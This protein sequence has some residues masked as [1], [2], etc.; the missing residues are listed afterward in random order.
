[1]KRFIWPLLM[2]LALAACSRKGPTPTSSPVPTLA[3]NPTLVSSVTPTPAGS[4]VPRITVVPSATR[5]QPTSQEATST[6]NA[7]PTATTEFAP[8]PLP[9]S[10]PTR[11]VIDAGPTAT[12]SPTATRP[13]SPLPTPTVGESPLDLPPT[14][15]GTVSGTV[16]PASTSTQG[17]AT[18]ESTVT[19]GQ[20]ATST[21]IPTTSGQA[22]HLEKV[23]THYDVEYQEFYIWGEAVNDADS[24]Q[25]IITLA[26][27]VYGRD[28][29]PL[30]SAEIES[31]LGYDEL[32]AAVRLPPTKGLAFGFR[33]L[34]PMDVPFDEDY[35]IRVEMEPIERGR[36]DLDITYDDYDP[37]DWP[38]Y[39]YVEGTFENPGPDLN[40]YVAIVVTIY[41]ED[42]EVVGLG[43]AYETDDPHL[44]TGEQDF[45]VEVEMWE[46]V[47]ELELDVYSYKV[48][49]FGY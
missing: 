9:S 14:A 18:P 5:L 29:N 36:D 1:M 16:T 39:F 33:V 37:L 2:L 43:W 30:T 31:P 34:L 27:V 42:D 10:T 19:G 4:P 38:D 40:E 44:Q 15:T 12:P 21:P 23:F 32:R 6:A 25:R 24:H 45:T 3:L 7:A 17:T 41:A 11:R 48:Q 13:E 22:W 47:G 28:G 49:T 35:E 8:T 26:P 46:I 20:S